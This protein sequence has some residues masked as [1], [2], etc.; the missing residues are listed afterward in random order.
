MR[1]FSF[2]KVGWWKK[3]EWVQSEVSKDVDVIT[4]K[5]AL[6]AA[7]HFRLFFFPVIHLVTELPPSQWWSWEEAPS[8]LLVRRKAL[9]SGQKST[10]CNIH[11]KHFQLKLGTY[12][13]LQVYTLQQSL[14]F[15]DMDL[16]LRR[17]R[18]LQN[19]WQQFRSLILMFRNRH[20]LYYAL[21]CV[22]KC[23]NDSSHFK[24]AV[25]VKKGSLFI[26]TSEPKSNQYISGFKLQ[27]CCRCVV[28]VVWLS[29]LLSNF[30]AGSFWSQDLILYW[31][32][33]TLVINEVQPSKQ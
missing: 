11:H 32:T 13:P 14:Y 24:K 9:N 18:D 6:N 26:V 22:L 27:F 29:F 25:S 19:S 16:H 23:A 1:K 20:Q 5:A 21:V 3:W 31:V 28:V 15:C 30:S 10:P 2:C 17:K 8:R 7:K 33:K 4:H 12:K